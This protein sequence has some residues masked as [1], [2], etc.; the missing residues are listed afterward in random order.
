MDYKQRLINEIKYLENK[1]I[2]ITATYTKQINSKKEEL[3]NK[4]EKYNDNFNFNR[5]IE[6]YN[7]SEKW[8]K[9]KKIFING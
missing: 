1:I 4:I 2:I 5:Y 7:D 3:N 8:R 9:I 6:F